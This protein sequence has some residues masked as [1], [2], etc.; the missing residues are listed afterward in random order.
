MLF[1]KLKPDGLV[2]F[3][4]FDSTTNQNI[5]KLPTFNNNL[6]MAD[7]FSDN[8]SFHSLAN[9]EYDDL[10]C[11]KKYSSDLKK[12]YLTEQQCSAQN[13]NCKN[14]FNFNSHKVFGNQT[15]TLEESQICDNEKKSKSEEIHTD[16]CSF[17]NKLVS[18]NSF[19][20]EKVEIKETE[21]LQSIDR[22]KRPLSC[23]SSNLNSK[24]VHFQPRSSYSNKDNT[25][26]CDNSDN[27][28]TNDN[29]LDEIKKITNPEFKQS[30]KNSFK[31][32]ESFSK[33]KPTK[34]E[35][36]TLKDLEN[37]L[38]NKNINKTNKSETKNLKK[39][40][41]DIFMM[42]DPLQNSNNKSGLSNDSLALQVKNL[43]EA[44][45]S[46][47]DFENYQQCLEKVC[48]DDSVNLS[49]AL[50]DFEN[51]DLWNYVKKFMPS[52]DPM[53]ESWLGEEDLKKLNKKSLSSKIFLD[54]NKVCSPINS[55][56]CSPIRN[57]AYYNSTKNTNTNKVESYKQMVNS[58][59]STPVSR[60]SNVTTSYTHAKSNENIERFHTNE[61]PSLSFNS[62]V[63]KKF[64]DY[65][66]S[67][68]FQSPIKFPDKKKDIYDMSNLLIDKHNTTQYP[69]RS[70]SE[71]ESYEEKVRV[72]RVGIKV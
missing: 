26:L 67:K 69:N 51:T 15:D 66:K 49:R 7:S 27:N 58:I 22:Y 21:T 55:F 24:S 16:L 6:T 33:C 3:T 25:Y 1:T 43:L 13:K 53:N 52:K 37:F 29:I 41:D 62:Y 12:K 35:K 70:N 63:N 68:E 64:E 50:N 8:F 48:K 23:N 31:K 14:S 20:V 59:T 17:R 45:S 19:E 9:V 47:L 71:D 56:C 72:T 60:T 46:T 4:T 42:L 57:K 65:L 44:S 28:Q 2:N 18:K 30:L 10:P 61:V 34:V 11:L 39:L 54:E 40:D 32:E 36:N 38:S 5:V